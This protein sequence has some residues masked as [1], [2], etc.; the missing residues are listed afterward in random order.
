MP[1]GGSRPNTGGARP[2]AGRKPGV[3]GRR[4]DPATLATVRGVCLYPWEWEALA[5]AAADGSPTREAARRLRASITDNR[6]HQEES[7]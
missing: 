5:A 3:P 1:R 2:G 6:N 4:R 7:P